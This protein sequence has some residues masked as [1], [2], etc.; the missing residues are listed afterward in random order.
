LEEGLERSY[1]MEYSLYGEYNKSLMEAIKVDM[2]LFQALS[3]RMES[4]YKSVVEYSDKMNMLK[5]V[6]ISKT[7]LLLLEDKLF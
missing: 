7:N 1:D 5:G 6:E 3:E 4:Q 2:S